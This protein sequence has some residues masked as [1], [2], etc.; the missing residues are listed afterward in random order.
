MPVAVP[1][2]ATALALIDDLRRARRLPYARGSSSWSATCCSR[3]PS[4]CARCWPCCGD[5]PEDAGGRRRVSLGA[6][7]PAALLP[8]RA[9]ELPA[10][11]VLAGSLMVVT[12]SMGEFNMTLAAAHAARQDAARRPC[13]RL[14]LAAARARQRLYAAVLRHDRAAAARHAVWGFRP[15]PRRDNSGRKRSEPITDAANPDRDSRWSDCAKTF[16]DGTRALEPVDFEI[17]RR[18]D[19][20]LS[21][22]IRLRQDHDPAHHRRPGVARRR[23]PRAVRWH[24]RYAAPDREAQR[25]HGVPVLRAVSEHER[26]R[27]H[28]LRPERSGVAEGGSRRARRARC[29]P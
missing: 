4:W 11:G 6:E 13:R 23:R 14:C 9:A 28:R 25:R 20:R 21:R 17:E 18:R 1:G 10:P 5:R 15:A 16:A 2:L 27:Q 24:R 8:H 12:L 29:W 26:G 19:G 22:A 3:C 7:L